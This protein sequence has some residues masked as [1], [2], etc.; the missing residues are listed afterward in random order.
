MLIK[1]LWER[2]MLKEKIN[3]HRSSHKCKAK[4]INWCGTEL[5][6]NV[7]SISAEEIKIKEYQNHSKHWDRSEYYLS[8]LC[9]KVKIEVYKY[10]KLLKFKWINKQIIFCYNIY[11][12]II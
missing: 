2:C 9:Y 7:L 8:A 11:Q 10:V 3:S 6:Y 12:I 1:Y 5:E 4:G